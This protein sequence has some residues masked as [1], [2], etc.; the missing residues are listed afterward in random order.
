MSE[1]TASGS[2]IDDLPDMWD[3][4]MRMVRPGLGLTAFGANIMNLPPDYSTRSHDE[5]RSGQEELYVRLDGSGWV[6][7]DDSGEKLALDEEHLCAV[8][9]GTARALASGP[10]GL[11]VLIVGSA[12]GRGYEPIDFG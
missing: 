4:F 11:R 5:S 6:V 2:A 3:G 12:P 7:L 1:L 10:E 8:G 9:P